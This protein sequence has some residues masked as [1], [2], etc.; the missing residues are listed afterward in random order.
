MKL[1][2]LI[3]ELN[4]YEDKNIQDSDLHSDFFNEKNC[5]NFI[6]I[7]SC[8]LYSNWKWIKKLEEMLS[9]LTEKKQRNFI[10]I[11]ESVVKANKKRYYV[12]LAVD[13]ERNEM[14]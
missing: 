2:K 4:L 10:A 7:L 5:K 13:V 12:F 6:Q 11:D 14:N 3:D 8:F 1:K 9:I